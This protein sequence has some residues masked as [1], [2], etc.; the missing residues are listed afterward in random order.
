[1]SPSFHPWNPEGKKVGRR[2]RRDGKGVRR[3][4]YDKDMKNL[5]R[6]CPLLSEV[7][8]RGGG[9]GVRRSYRR[10]IGRWRKEEW[11]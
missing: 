8:R 9:R 4:N 6:S 1:L 10:R 7:R 3:I 5:V 11:K 2:E